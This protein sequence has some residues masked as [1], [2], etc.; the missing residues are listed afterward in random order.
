MIFFLDRDG[1]IN[2]DYNF[3]HK[4]EEWTFCEGAP[5]AIRRMNELGFKV[6][7]VTNQSGIIRGRFSLAQVVALH[8]WVD[9]ELAK[10]GARIDAWHIAPWHPQ[11]HEKLDPALLH[12]RKPGTGM[13]EKAL[14]R[15]EADSAR[16]FMAGDKVSD[17]QPALELGM[18][19]ILIRSRHFDTVDMDW[20]RHHK[21]D[22][23]DTLLDAVNQYLPTPPTP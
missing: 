18:K 21:I 10:H 19:P 8:E 7:V 12:D 14:K 23:F 13:F 4:P 15:F 22:V 3:V 20:I 9:A 5:E 16:C 2:V 17:L 11:M 1:T 6:V